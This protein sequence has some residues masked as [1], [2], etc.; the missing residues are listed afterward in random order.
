[1]HTW[2]TSLLAWL[3]ASNL[4]ETGEVIDTGKVMTMALLHDISE[5]QIS[6]IPHSAVR[7]G[8]RVMKDGKL[9]AEYAAIDDIFD[10]QCSIHQNSKSIIT[11][12]YEQKSLESRIVHGADILDMLLHA[13]SL[14]RNGVNPKLLKPFFDSGE[15]KLASLNIMLVSEIYS[16]IEAEHKKNLF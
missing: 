14:E 10:S 15:D 9:S 5:S 13:I 8:G 6:D 2:G 4:S 3:I 11:E 1:E 16:N 12:Y 7:L